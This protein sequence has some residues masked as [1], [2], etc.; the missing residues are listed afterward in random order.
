MTDAEMT[1]TAD[2]RH[3]AAA[4]AD[5]DHVTAAPRRRRRWWLLLVLAVLAVV[6]VR[7]VLFEWVFPIIERHVDNPELGGIEQPVDPA[8][9]TGLPAP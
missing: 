9:T 2:E 6:W 7:L 1:R 3:E 8:D 4:S 5:P